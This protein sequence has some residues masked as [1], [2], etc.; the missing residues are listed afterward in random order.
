[1]EIFS[2]ALSDFDDLFVIADIRQIQK[3]NS[4]QSSQVGGLEI[5]LMILKN[6]MKLLNLYI[7]KQI[8]I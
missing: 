2:T 4:W 8:I 1:M 6:W 5:K 3:L 7:I